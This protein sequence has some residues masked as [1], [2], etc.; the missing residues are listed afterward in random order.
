MLGFLHLRLVVLLSTV[1]KANWSLTTESNRRFGCTC[2]LKTSQALLHMHCIPDFNTI[3][4]RGATWVNRAGGSLEQGALCLWLVSSGRLKYPR[5]KK[6]QYL[7]NSIIDNKIS[8]G[9]REEE[10]WELQWVWTSTNRSR[11][12]GRP[13]SCLQ[14]QSL[15]APTTSCVLLKTSWSISNI[16]EHVMRRIS[17]CVNK[18]VRRRSSWSD[19]L[20]ILWNADVK[21]QYLAQGRRTQWPY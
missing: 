3:P 1:V 15:F 18:Q 16:N 17:C 10:T 12:W 6:K 13:W 14:E 4:F 7:H 8:S 11:V 9:W 19:S 20:E 5:V 2:L 21:D